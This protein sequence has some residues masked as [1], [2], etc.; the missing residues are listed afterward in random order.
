MRRT[1]L[2]IPV[3]AFALGLALA[4]WFA[5]AYGGNTAIPNLTAASAGADADNLITTQ[6]GTGNTALKQPLSA[7]WTWIQTHLLPISAGGTGVT[8]A[9]GNGSK[10][11]LST[12]STTT[13]DAVKFDATGNTVDAGFAPGQG[14]VTTVMAGAGIANNNVGGLSPITITGFVYIDASYIPM[15]M[16]GLGFSN[17]GVSPQTVIDIA[18]G[19]ATSDD[20]TMLLKLAGFT[21]NANTTWTVGTG[22]GCADGAGGYTSLGASTWY[23]VFLIGRPDTGVVD[24]L[25]S[26]SATSPTQPSVSYTKQ[27]RI[28]SFKTDG[29]NHI[30][31]VTQVGNIFYWNTSAGVTFSGD[32]TLGTTAVLEPVTGTLNVPT[33]VKVQPIL[34]LTVAGTGNAVICNSPDEPD[35]LPLAATPT[36]T[37]PGFDNLD[38]TLT[39]GDQ[40]AVAPF[41]TTNTAAQIRCRATAASTTV[42]FVTRGWIE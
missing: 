23:H 19:A 35:I 11:Q 7:L 26:L 12:G 13:G 41:M 34:R 42:A 21:K 27:R 15:F 4:S 25:C 37:A 5:Y 17:D 28:F 6:S 8:A 1:T 10:V 33:G 38:T 22:N 18:S 2:I 39:A 3:L 24:V 30:L 16:G 32:T 31:G 40:N 29:S 9:Q 36:T 20:S 14:S